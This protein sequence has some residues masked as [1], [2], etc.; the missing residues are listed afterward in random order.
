MTIK[1]LLLEVGITPEYLGFHYL[2]KNIEIVKKNFEEEQYSFKYT[3]IYYVIA[4]ELGSTASRVERA[5][6]HAVE[7]AFN[8][9]SP[10]LKELFG[11]YTDPHS[12]KVSLSC[13]I[14]V[15][16]NYLIETETND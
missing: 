4:K 6:R 8:R 9:P 16:A 12:G 3:A 5:M 1:N 13:F 11:R 2:E 7:V 14:A 10:K 15:L